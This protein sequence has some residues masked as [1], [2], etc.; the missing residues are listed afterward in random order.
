MLIQGLNLLYVEDF[1]KYQL[2]N[3]KVHL[4]QGKNSRFM[5]E[6]SPEHNDILEQRTK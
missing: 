6:T 4:L 1:L 3:H 5:A 2:C